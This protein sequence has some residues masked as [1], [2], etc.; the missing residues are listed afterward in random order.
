M[1]GSREV[2]REVVSSTS[3]PSGFARRQA[4][5]ST[6]GWCPGNQIEHTNKPS[7]ALSIQP[8]P[9]EFWW[10]FSTVSGSPLES[11]PE[12]VWVTG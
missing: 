6:L 8:V 10:R 2:H 3:D 9:W 7:G 1:T 11:P 4:P 12:V 5:W